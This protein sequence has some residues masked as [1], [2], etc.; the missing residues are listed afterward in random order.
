MRRGV[1][2]A[3]IFMMDVRG[4]G[5]SQFRALGLKAADEQ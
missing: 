1:C 2:L 5:A 4:L 3:V